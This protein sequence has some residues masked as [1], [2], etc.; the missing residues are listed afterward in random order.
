VESPAGLNMQDGLYS[1]TN[2]TW[3]MGRISYGYWIC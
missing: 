1:G 3:I 2:I